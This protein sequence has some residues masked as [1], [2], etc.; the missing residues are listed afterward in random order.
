M[1]LSLME[2]GR[3]EDSTGNIT[4]SWG[5]NYLDLNFNITYY[6]SIEAYCWAGVPV[7][8]KYQG[9]ATVSESGGVYTYT[10]SGTVL[11]QTWTYTYANCPT[12]GNKTVTCGSKTFSLSAIAR[13]ANGSPADN[14]NTVNEEGDGPGKTSCTGLPN[15]WINTATLNLFVQDRVCM[16]PGRGPQLAMTHSY[17]A[18]PARV[19]MFGMGWSFAYQ[20]GITKTKNG[21][22]ATTATLKKGSGQEIDYGGLIYEYDEPPKNFTPPSGSG[23]PDKLTWMGDYWLWVEKDTHWTYRFDKSVTGGVTSD[24]EFRLTSITDTGNN[25]LNISYTPD[26]LIESITDAPG[27]I[28]FFTYDSSNRVTRM[29]APDG[30]FATYAYDSRHNLVQSVDLF[31]ATTIYTYDAGGLMTSL[32]TDGQTTQFQYAAVAGVLRISSVTDANGKTTRYAMVPDPYGYGPTTVTKTDPLGNNIVYTSTSKAFTS[33]VTDPLTNIFTTEYAGGNPVAITDAL[34]KQTTKTYDARGNVTRITDAKGYFTTFTY[35]SNDNMTGTTDAL[36]KISTFTYD[37]KSNLIK[38]ASPLN[39]QTVMEYDDLGQMTGMTDAAGN[40][41]IFTYN[42]FGNLVSTTDPLGNTTSYTY[43]AVG[44]NKTSVTDA[45]GNKTTF[46]FDANNRLTGVTHPDGTFRTYAYD[47]CSMTGITDEKGNTTTFTHDKVLNQTKVIDPAGSLTEMMYDGNGNLITVRDPLSRSTTN[48]YDTANRPVR[49][50]NPLSGSITYSYDGNGN[51][52]TLA[53]ERSKQTQFTYDVNNRL[54]TNTDPLNEV[55]QF[56]RD[57]LNRVKQI[58]TP[59]SGEILYHFDDDGRMTDKFFNATNVASITRDGNGNII[60]VIDPVGSSTY[61]YSSR[62]ELTGITWQDGATATF[63]YDEVGNIGGIQYPETLSAT[64][65]Y[66]SRNRVQRITWGGA[67]VTFEYDPVGNLVKETRSNGTVSEY[68]YDAANRLTGVNHK[69]GT[70]SFAQVH[71]I[72]DAA[73]NIVNENSSTATPLTFAAE[74]FNG[75]YNDANQIS[76]RGSDAYTYDKNGN[77]TTVTGTR[78]MNATYDPE[79][80]LLSL[81]LS[82]TTSTYAYNGLG[83]RVSKSQGSGTTNYHYD[84]LGRL[85]FETD[86][87]GNVIASYCYAGGILAAM[88]ASDGSVYYYHFDKTG[89]TLAMTDAAGNV[90]N[91]YRYE[92]FGKV[93]THTGAVRNP[94]TYVGAF[95]VMDEGD[96]IYYMKNRYYD[97]N[98]GKFMQKD[99]IGFAGGINLYA[100]VGNNPVDSVDPEGLENSPEFIANYKAR[101]IANRATREMNQ[102]P[103]ALKQKSLRELKAGFDYLEKSFPEIA[104]EMLKITSID[105]TLEGAKG[106]VDWRG[107]CVINVSLHT[108]HTPKEIAKTLIH[109]W[110]H[111]RQNS[112][113]WIMAGTGVWRVG[114]IPYMM[115]KNQI[116]GRSDSWDI[117]ESTA[118]KNEGFIK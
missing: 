25:Q 60:S 98:T 50:T 90:V 82:E 5:C 44:I 77:L 16:Y 18:D 85:L 49:H 2:D 93:M 42:D 103:E 95:G 87:N 52:T 29:D 106:R 105:D 56:V 20:Y 112:N 100:Y 38:I 92:P 97:A 84:H 74:T 104:A 64:Y 89:N 69:K 14:N 33:S 80:R 96:G 116:T 9:H 78:P 45:R 10:G 15:Y 117:L 111:V 8:L 61:A 108:T 17:N 19:G 3:I 110:A 12:I 62:N 23:N 68:A 43:D 35:D 39:N 13:G 21:V 55:T 40:K 86:Q 26:N 11:S 59:Q 81:A 37:A 101:T 83:A 47:C 73:G 75:V 51:L 1:D 28:T 70:S 27:R 48:S 115:L 107:R 72:R 65:E 34:G 57:E 114:G 66:D 94:F 32:S 24:T 79:N 88:Q 71:Y 102:S 113:I 91:A 6:D 41:T 76:T 118:I 99:P 7:E 31:G 54:L 4:G 36:G 46:S 109:E 22:A 63:T 58:I 67:T 53:D 30:R